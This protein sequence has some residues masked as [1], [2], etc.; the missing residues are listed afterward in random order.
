MDGVSGRASGAEASDASA[1]EASAMDLEGSGVPGC[2]PGVVP[3]A[4]AGAQEGG[5]GPTCDRCENGRC[6]RV[7]ASGHS[8][9][10]ALAVTSSEV[11]WASDGAIVKVPIG[12]GA[13]QTLAQSDTVLALAIDSGYVYWTAAPYPDGT[14]MKAPLTGGATTT[15]ATGQD[16]EVA[17]FNVAVSGGIVYWIAGGGIM[18]VPTSGGSPVVFQPGLVGP[19]ALAAGRAYW[20][21]NEDAGTYSTI[22]TRELA[23]GTRAANLAGWNLSSPSWNSNLV[24][25]TVY[26]LAVSTTDV[27]WAMGAGFGGNVDAGSLMRVSFC[28]GE[29]SPIDDG[30]FDTAVAVDD[31]SVYWA[32]RDANFT[33]RISKAPRAGGAPVVVVPAVENLTSLVLDATSVYYTENGTIVEVTPK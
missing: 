23:A 12:G 16:F 13:P 4:D 6:F 27:Y 15:L 3:R 22:Q 28:G 14:V 33:Y 2:V 20:F 31:D 18:S 32:S 11:V 5:C 19:M 25:A 7:L 21:Q 1:G 8:N 24:A 10:S 29:A 9:P 17:A 30:D 26:Q